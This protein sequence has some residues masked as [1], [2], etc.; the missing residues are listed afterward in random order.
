MLERITRPARSAMAMP[1]RP[2]DVAAQARA[3]RL[4]QR[5]TEDGTANRPDTSSDLPALAEQEIQ[6]AIHSDRERCLGDLTAHLRAERD[7]LA[8]LQTAMD[9]AGMRQAAGEAIAYFAAIDASHGSS[10][11][12]A[13][14][15]AASIAEE[16]QEFRRHNRLTRT[17]RQPASRGFTWTLMAF[18][19]VVEG[20]VNAVFFAGGS[21]LGLVGGAMMAAMFSAFNVTVGVLNGLFPLRWAHHRNPMIKLAGLIAFPALCIGSIA[22]NA[23]IAHYRD[24]AQTTPAADPLK[25]AY[26]G[27]LQNPFGLRNIESW[28]LF[29]LGLVFAG[30]AVAK[31]FALDD[32]HPGYGAHDR[33]HTAARSAYDDARQDVLDQASEVRDGFTSEARE[34]IETLRGSSSQRQHLLAARAR[35]LNE[36]EAHEANLAQA[37]QQLLTLYRVANQAARS[38]PPPYRFVSVFR[39]DDHAIERP[40]LRSLLQDQ[41]LEVDADGLIQE[42]DSLREKVLQR[43]DIIL[44]DP[45][46]GSPA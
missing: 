10:L 6:A 25:A 42:L 44:R 33:R 38:T 43:Y 39:F 29:G 13:K 3:Y 4:E 20:V 28:L 26:S 2:V 12:Q 5:G 46:L 14:E 32:P 19:I 9:I 45:A 1:Y 35:N 18:L 24:V 37:A 40:A 21:D 34:K 11:A 31:G 16:L 7:A 41:G 27:L 17:A 23:F 8:H 36:F 22:L 15:H 30:F